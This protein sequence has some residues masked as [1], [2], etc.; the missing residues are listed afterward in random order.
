MAKPWGPNEPNSGNQRWSEWV[1]RVRAARKRRP[2]VDVVRDAFRR[3][4]RAGFKSSVGEARVRRHGGIYELAL[5]I[6]GPP[7]HD[8][9]F[10][11]AVRKD[12]FERFVCTGFGVGATLTMEARL[13]A[14][15]YED[16]RP[17]SHLV[18]AP[19]LVMTCAP[20]R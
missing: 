5:H 20:M 15:S 18:V 4:V 10:R 9:A 19:S 12:F 2:P 8:A 3:W 17:S 6:E 14:G 1:F 13:L 7:V 16:G 11:D